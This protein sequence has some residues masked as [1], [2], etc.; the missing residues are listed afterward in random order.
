ME[1]GKGSGGGDKGVCVGGVQDET[2][3]KGARE[4]LRWQAED[5]ASIGALLEV[6]VDAREKERCVARS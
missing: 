1:A 2:G 3:T 4:G 6:D 5:K